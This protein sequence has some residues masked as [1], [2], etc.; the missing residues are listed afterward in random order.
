M[1]KPA[2]IKVLLADDHALVREGIRAS[3]EQSGAISIVG[4]AC[5]GRE[6]LQKCKELRPDLVLMDLNM[7][8]MS[9]LEAAPLVR[10]NCPA[11]K[12]I[13]LTIHDSPE[14]VTR[15]LRSGAHGY[16]LKD[17]SPGDLL[18]AIQFVAGGQAY[19]SPS[20]SR[21][22][23]ENFVEGGEADSR[24]SEREKD[25]LR[26]IDQGK[27]SK[28]IASELKLSARTVETYRVRV[29]RKLNARNVADLLKRARQHGLI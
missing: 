16:V 19:F 17:T 15:L 12:I 4:E 29:K 3:L 9:G 18:R 28:E 2:K 22:L 14:Y 26:R 25:V 20:V 7:P 1:P 27:T 11:T 8:E 13:I 21:I 10:K 6:A 24:V 23:L 5:N